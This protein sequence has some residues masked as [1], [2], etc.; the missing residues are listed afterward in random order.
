[1]TAEESRRWTWPIAVSTV[2]AISSIFPLPP[3][4][5]LSN[6]AAVPA[7]TLHFPIAYHLLAPASVILDTLTLLAPAQYLGTLGLGAI[8]Y[9]LCIA[10]RSSPRRGRAS[11]PLL[12]LGFRLIVGGLGLAELALVARR[13]MA[14]LTLRDPELLAIDFH[15]HTSAS[16]DGRPSF[17][18]E[19]NREW[20]SSAGFAAA[21]VTDH[22]TLEGAVSAANFNP[23]L[24][25]SGTTLLPGVELRDGDEHPILIGIDPLR[26]HITSG[27][28]QPALIDRDN[29]PTPAVL[30]LSLPGDLIRVPAEMTRGRVRVAGIEV[31]DGSPRGIAQAGRDRQM[32]RAFATRSSVATVSGSDNHG[33]GRTAPAWSVMRISGWRTMTPA[34]LDVAIRRTLIDE[35]PRAV[36]VV[37]RRTAPIPRTRASVAIS[38]FA[39]VIVMLRTMSMPDRISC[40]VWCWTLCAM[41]RLPSHLK[42]RGRVRI[43][44]RLP[45]AA[46]VGAAASV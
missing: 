6:P 18:A 31:S 24:A 45:Q 14:S 11:R 22:R 42:E 40:C 38:G 32:I 46:D 13:P 10:R 39:V 17:G 23:G 34:E 7:G 35:G 2:L 4:I 1:M 27:D 33:W 12:T 9:I 30:L 26:T 19:E 28:W 8:T 5:D 15:S 29:D 43:R 25:G 41:L 21:Y 3:L 37:A 44:T 36:Q 16:H 20:H